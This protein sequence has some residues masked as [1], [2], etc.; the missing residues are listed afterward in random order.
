MCF[1]FSVHCLGGGNKTEDYKKILGNYITGNL[2]T[3]A[4]SKEQ[5]LNEINDIAKT[6]YVDYLPDGWYDLN[7]S[8]IIQSS[9]NG[10]FILY[11]GYVPVGKTPATDSRGIIIILDQN[12]KPIKTIYEFSSGTKLLPIQKMIQIED[13]TFV[14]VD[15]TI[16]A[17]PIGT[18]GI[19]TNNKRFIMLNNFSTPDYNNDYSVV[20][21]KSYNLPSAYRNI[22]AID[23]ART[24]A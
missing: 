18:T 15:S 4:P 19:M 12:M 3:T 13:G 21:R 17:T 24:R 11:G 6:E 9:T 5:I 22:F 16:F 20:L 10:N 23:S 14:A 7:L 1:E 2:E 8:N